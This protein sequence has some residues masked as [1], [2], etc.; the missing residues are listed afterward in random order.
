MPEKTEQERQAMIA[1]LREVEVK[2]AWRCV[3]A[4]A[5]FTLLAV[6]SA[7]AAWGIPRY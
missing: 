6:G 5:V 1:T 4:L 3:C 2:W 7:L